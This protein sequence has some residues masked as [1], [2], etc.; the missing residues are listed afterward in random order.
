MKANASTRN[1]ITHIQAGAKNIPVQDEV[2]TYSLLPVHGS[3]GP[4]TVDLSVPF[5]KQ[6]HRK[7]RKNAQILA[8]RKRATT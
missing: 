7:E 6:E 5:R 2:Y 1:Q 8:G 3:L 4:S